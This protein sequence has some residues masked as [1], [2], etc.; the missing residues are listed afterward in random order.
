M[1]AILGFLL[2]QIFTKS[3]S[4]LWEHKG[5]LSLYI[6]TLLGPY[7]NKKIRFSLSYLIRIRIPNTD[8][9]LLVP[10]RRIG[11]QLQPVGGVYKRYGDDKL[12]ESWNYQS[13][14]KENGLGTDFWSEQDLRFRITGKH[15]IKAIKWFEEGKEREV[16][17]DREFYEELIQPGVLDAEVF[18]QIRYKHLKRFSKN[19]KWSDYHQCFEVLIYDVFDFL[20]SELQKKALTELDQKATDLND[21]FVIV[22][23]EDIEKL[24]LCSK[25]YQIAKI[26]QHTK[27]I[28][29]Q[30]F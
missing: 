27:L 16:S 9:Y 24:R 30:T 15:T 5:F 4:A 11:N 19:L 6:R 10:N 18:S 25:G 2:K 23:C 13:D 28:I 7:R 1:E 22:E 3:V 12:F 14:S 17:I 29:N 20:P 26:G 21:K 8:R